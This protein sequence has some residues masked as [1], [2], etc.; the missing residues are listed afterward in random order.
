MSE[1][2]FGLVGVLLGGLIGHRLAIGRDRRREYNEI[3]EPLRVA[4][5]KARDDIE[6]GYS[7]RA[8][9]E[10]DI[11][12]VRAFLPRRK[13]EEFERVLERYRKAYRAALVPDNMGGQVVIKDHT[14]QVLIELHAIEAL[15]KRR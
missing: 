8:F 5:L 14:L 7:W 1:L 2:L 10:S 6:R 13:K 4:S 3:V 12:R 15:L 9:N 11:D